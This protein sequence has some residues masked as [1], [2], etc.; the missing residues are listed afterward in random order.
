M[1]RAGGAAEEST[2][3]RRCGWKKFKGFLRGLT[4]RGFSYVQKATFSR[5]V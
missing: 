1:N 5:H 3:N 4:Y 2:V